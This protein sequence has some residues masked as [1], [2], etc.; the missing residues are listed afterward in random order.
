MSDTPR[1]DDLWGK[2]SGTNAELA[3]DAIVLCG[4]LEREVQGWKTKWECAVEMAAIAEIE[5]DDLRRQLTEEY[6]ATNTLINEIG[7]KRMVIA[8][9][10][11]RIATALKIIGQ[12]PP[13]DTPGGE[14]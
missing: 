5:R 4:D 13:V 14:G 6:R 8:V 2:H 12:T 1:T 9:L 7:N 11:S 10:K 3:K